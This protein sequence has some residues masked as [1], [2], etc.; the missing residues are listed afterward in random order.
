VANANLRIEMQ[1]GDTVA[2]AQAQPNQQQ[3]PPNQPI[4]TLLGS[5]S[6]YSSSIRA[7]GSSS[8]GLTEARPEND[9]NLSLLSPS[10]KLETT[11]KHEMKELGPHVLVCSVSYLARVVDQSGQEQ[12]VERDFRK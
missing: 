2:Q 3:P 6:S 10:S 9:L 7:S 12:W 11:V 8:Q 4:K 1:V 5:I